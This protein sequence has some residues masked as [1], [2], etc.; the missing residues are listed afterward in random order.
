M[1]G[2][3]LLSLLRLESCRCGDVSWPNNVESYTIVDFEVIFFQNRFFNLR[4]T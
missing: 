4:S 3:Q 2:Q 1:I